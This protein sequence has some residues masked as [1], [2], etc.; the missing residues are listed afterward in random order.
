MYICIIISTYLLQK[1]NK[2]CINRGKYIHN[3][4]LYV[5]VCRKQ[6]CF[7]YLTAVWLCYTVLL[8][9]YVEQYNYVCYN[10]VLI[11]KLV[12]NSRYVCYLHIHNYSKDI[13]VLNNYRIQYSIYTYL[14]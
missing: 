6:P 2:V 11:Q 7:V 5:C 13:A 8:L 14:G 4:L 10:T 3:V 1:Y 12:I 9:L